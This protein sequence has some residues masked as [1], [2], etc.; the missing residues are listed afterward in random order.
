MGRWRA[1]TL[2]IEVRRGLQLLPLIYVNQQPRQA[3]GLG[4]HQCQAWHPCILQGQ[5]A[6]VGNSSGPGLSGNWEVRRQQLPSHPQLRGT[7]SGSAQLQRRFW[8][9]LPPL[10]PWVVACGC[11]NYRSLKWHAPAFKNE[12]RKVKG[13]HFSSAR[14]FEIRFVLST[15]DIKNVEHLSLRWNSRYPWELVVRNRDFQSVMHVPW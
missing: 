11:L 3:G 7:S 9:Q 12:P 4:P 8:A 15:F 13:S 10:P 5:E 6:A 14:T 1:A 2:H